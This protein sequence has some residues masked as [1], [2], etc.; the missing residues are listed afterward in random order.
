MSSGKLYCCALRCYLP[1]CLTD[2]V[3]EI[4]STNRVRKQKHTLEC[5]LLYKPLGQSLVCMVGCIMIITWK[6]LTVK[7]IGFATH[8]WLLTEIWWQKTARGKIIDGHNCFIMCIRVPTLFSVWEVFSLSDV[9]LVLKCISH[10][11]WN[12]IYFDK[13]DGLLGEYLITYYKQVHL[14]HPTH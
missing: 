2:L 13:Y 1:S 11:Q 6:Q 3:L 5:H 14:F 9:K 7:Y 10:N 4:I 12:F 8:K